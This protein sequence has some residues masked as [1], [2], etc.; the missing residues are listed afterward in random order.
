MQIDEDEIKK[1][2]NI[3][4][5]LIEPLDDHLKAAGFQTILEYLLR[6]VQSLYSSLKTEIESSSPTVRKEF[7]LPE[8]IKIVNPQSYNERTLIMAYNL[9]KSKNVEIFNV[10]DINQEYTKVRMPRPSNQN[11][12]INQLIGKGLFM[13]VDKRKDGKK[14][15]SITLEGENAVQGKIRSKK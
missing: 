10:D 1:K 14:A 3:A 6:G 7:S 15:F 5:R 2:I 13:E 9:L 12:V 8:L 11:D 4:L